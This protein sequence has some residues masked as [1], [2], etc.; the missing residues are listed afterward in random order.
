[1]KLFDGVDGAGD[2]LAI[3]ELVGEPTEVPVFQRRVVGFCDRVA[4]TPDG[5]IR[6]GSAKGISQAGRRDRKEDH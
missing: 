6:L 3:S 1:V 4:A 2:Q 5:V